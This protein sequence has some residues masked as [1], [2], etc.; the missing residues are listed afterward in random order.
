M[1]HV[2]CYIATFFS[3][4]FPQM[5]LHSRVTYFIFTAQHNLTGTG[6][7]SGIQMLPSLKSPECFVKYSE[8]W[9]WTI[10]CRTLSQAGLTNRVQPYFQLLYF[11]LL[12]FSVVC[13]DYLC[14]Y[15][16]IRIQVKYLVRANSFNCLTFFSGNFTRQCISICGSH[17]SSCETN[18]SLLS[19][20]SQLSH[21][22]L[23]YLQPVFN[24][25]LA[26]YILCSSS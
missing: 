1:S 25:S 5:L 23:T 14:L 6:L 19:H 3:K 4:L 7:E 12:V 2:S 26:S 15:Q 18:L 16:A 24:V 9:L 20:K 21:S 13:W 11:Y 22:P 17:L 8:S 10:A